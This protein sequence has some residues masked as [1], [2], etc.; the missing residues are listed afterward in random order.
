MKILVGLIIICGALANQCSNNITVLQCKHAGPQCMFTGSNCLQRTNLRVG[1][2]IY[3]KC[4]EKTNK[5][6]C[7]DE[8]KNCIWSPIV[9]KCL[10][11][12]EFE[13][14]AF[15]S[16]KKKCLK[17][18]RCVWLEKYEICTFDEK[19]A[20]QV[21]SDLFDDYGS[22][23]IADNSGNKESENKP[24]EDNSGNRPNKTKLSNGSNEASIG[25][26]DSDVLPTKEVLK[27][28]PKK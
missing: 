2:M 6:D 10:E 23:T 18:T 11:Q 8:Y 26:I 16:C 22:L 13:I 15:V 25:S 27:E 28:I 21:V 9:S 4:A 19:R 17:R 12:E 24:I 20:G 3:P 1:N 7:F 5:M 14:C